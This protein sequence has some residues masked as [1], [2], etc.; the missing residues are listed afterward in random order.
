MHLAAMGDHDKVVE[1]L[2]KKGADTEL[3]DMVSHM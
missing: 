2:L 1:F 3:K